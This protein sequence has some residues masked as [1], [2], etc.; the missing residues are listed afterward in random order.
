M[1][2]GVKG[3]AAHLNDHGFTMR[4]NRWRK[5]LI[6]EML[7]NRLYLG[8]YTFNK[9]EAKTRRL[10]PESEWITF[11]IEPVVTPDTFNQVQQ[12]LSDRSPDKVPPRITTSPTLLTGF[13]KCGSCG[14]NMTIATGKGGRYRYYKCSSR[15][16]DLATGSNCQSNN[17]P[18]D[19][20]DGL[21][22]DAIAN[23]VFTP[24]RVEIMMKELQ[25]NLKNSRTDHDEQLRKLT[26]E[27]DA[28]KRQ[29]ER[30]Y[31]AVEKGLLPL[32]GTLQ[33]RVH[34]H[35]ARRQEVLTEMAGLRRQKELPLAQLG[36]KHVNAFCS[37]LKD[38]LRD[39]GSNFG[40]EYLKL[41]VDEI[42]VD[43]KEVRLTG[44]YCSLAGALR[45]STKSGQLLGVP[46]F[47]PVWLPSADSNHGQGG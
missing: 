33:E 36:R 10:K 21:I 9:L 46:S 40:K 32:D 14:A 29:T 42:R 45:M 27:L 11:Q 35:Q 37:A 31:E 26:K 6:H 16:N 44:S 28:I 41:L 4:G 22:L 2:L 39:K 25:N 30:L 19:K 24:E 20:L 47:V 18:M 12:R 34:K 13:I 17:I 43:K 5:T 23:R 3:I 15:I 8:E 38:K 1:A 7:A